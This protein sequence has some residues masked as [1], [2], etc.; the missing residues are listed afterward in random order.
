MKT[1]I[2]KNHFLLNTPI[3]HRGK[4]DGTVA[5]NTLSAFEKTIQ[6]EYAIEI[7]V[8]LTKDNQVIVFHDADLKRLCNVDKRVED[9]NLAEIKKIKIDNK[10]P[11]PTFTEFLNLV[12]GRVPILIEIKNVNKVGALEDLVIESLKKY[13]GKFAVMAFNPRVLTYLKEKA[14]D[15]IRGQLSSFFKNEKLAFYKKF[16]LSRMFFNKKN[17]P[18]FIAYD[19]ENLPNRFVKKYKDIPLLAWTIRTKEDLNK[20]KSVSVKNVIFE[21]DTIFNYN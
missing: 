8:Q 5:E 14:P 9:L 6:K 11:I 13:K 10:Y 18:D 2:D 21:N 17:Q 1:R 12:N 4:I 7:D 16:L 15:I 20:A 19:L 3:C